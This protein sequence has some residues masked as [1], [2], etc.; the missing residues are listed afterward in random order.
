MLTIKTLLSKVE[1]EI[2]KYIYTH[3]KEII[4]NQIKFIKKIMSKILLNLCIF[5][6]V[7]A[8]G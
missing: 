3:L 5:Q 6:N 1:N 7:E 4:L 8:E 2:E